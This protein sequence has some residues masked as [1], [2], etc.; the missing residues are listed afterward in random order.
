MF[1]ARQSKQIG[2]SGKGYPMKYIKVK[3][4]EK[5]QHYK[6][7][8]P[9]WI[10]L[11][12]E[13]I[14]EFDAD[15]N[16]KKFYKLPDSAKL[17][18]I[19]LACL[20]AH[21]NQHIPYPNDKW[22]KKR[23]GIRKLNLQPLINNGFICIDTE[24]VSEPHRNDTPEREGETERETEKDKLFLKWNSY[25]GKGNWRS[26]NEITPEISDA[27]QTM[28]KSYTVE[29]ITG[30]IENYATVLLNPDYVWS[31]AWTLYQFLTRHR[32]DN[33]AELQFYRFLN[34][35]FALQDF[36]LTASG[37]QKQQQQVRQQKKGGSDETQQMR[38]YFESKTIDELKEMLGWP[39]FHTSI[40]LIKEIMSERI[41]NELADKRGN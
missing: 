29:Q 30:A 14:D 26:H 23:L 24:S 3:N 35:N 31:Y 10:K 21:Y 28:L 11:L 2:F 37:K 39:K 33:R 22:L 19:L 4:W 41:K 32:P 13:I 17:T 15:G 34:N 6:D 8:R 5:F 40:W 36:Q 18:F 9:T 1:F 25:K 7:R 38:A 20:R 16:S 27:I 12:I